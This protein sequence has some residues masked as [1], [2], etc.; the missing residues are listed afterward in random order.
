[1]NDA[2]I[3]LQGAPNF[4]DIGGHR[5]ADG[6]R[7]R[8][9]RVFRSGELSHL[10]DADLDTVRDLDIALVTDLRSLD[11]TSV[12]RTRWPDGMATEMHCAD[13]TV[14]VLINGRPIMDLMREI[15]T[16]EEATRIFGLGFVEIPDYCGPALKLITERLAAGVGPVVYHCTNGRD[17][18][19]IVSAMLLYML[20]ASHETIVRDFLITNERINVEQ[21]IKNS[22]AAYKGMGIDV[23]R[24]IFERAVLV[25][26]EYI[27]VMIDGLTAKYGSLDGYLRHFG[28]DDTLRDGLRSC[29]L[30]SA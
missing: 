28:I 18:T 2:D 23:S 27:D 17:R 22:I 19:G 13:I 10:T 4:R 7:I 21:V 16:V 1:M 14:H 30:E 29:L 12:H 24:E 25:R 26:P 3:R 9:G 6:R 20:G 11:E 5:V 8:R 15:D